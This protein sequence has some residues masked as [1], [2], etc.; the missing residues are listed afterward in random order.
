MPHSVAVAAVLLVSPVQV[1]CLAPAALPV[2]QAA[3]LRA[4][5]PCMRGTDI[6]FDTI[7][8]WDEQLRE[9][10]A[11]ME[12]HQL[13]QPGWNGMDDMGKVAVYDFTQQ[14]AQQSY[15]QPGYV[16]DLPA[17]WTTG[18]D[19]SS[20]ATYYYHEQTGQSQWDPPQQGYSGPQH[21]GY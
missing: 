20:G 13:S 15:A 10:A 21:A 17:G 2:R 12:E 19:E 16:Q 11:W 3:S 7:D 1:L 4:G 8:S 5:Q 6:D 9:Q 14:G 18:V